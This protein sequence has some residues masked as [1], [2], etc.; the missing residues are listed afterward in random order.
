DAVR[1]YVVE[2]AVRWVREFHV[3]GLRLDAVHAII[4]TSAV[5]L[6]EEL[7]AAVHAEAER[8]GRR[9]HVIAESALAG[10]RLVRPTE[11]GGYGLD[12]QWLDDAHHALHVALTGETQGY[13]GDYEGLADIARALRDRYVHAGRYSPHR[14]RTVGRPAPD[15]PYERF[16]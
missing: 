6:L 1:R 12:G 13:L 4:D 8:L 9:V 7:A 2:N 3:D 14:R 16:V 5:H 11:V 10:P 15:V